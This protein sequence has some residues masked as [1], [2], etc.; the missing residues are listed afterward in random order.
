[1]RST[2]TTSSLLANLRYFY[3]VSDELPPLHFNLSLSDWYFFS[4]CIYKSFFSGGHPHRCSLQPWLQNDGASPRSCRL[5]P[6]QDASEW[7]RNLSRSC[8]GA[9][10][11]SQPGSGFHSKAFG[12]GQQGDLWLMLMLRTVLML[13][14]IIIFLLLLLLIKFFKVCALLEVNTANFQCSYIDLNAWDLFANNTPTM[15]WERWK[16]TNKFAQYSFLG[17]LTSDVR[18]IIGSLPVTHA[19]LCQIQ[20]LLK[21]IKTLLLVC[22]L[23]MKE[24]RLLFLFCP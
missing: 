23:F 4:W 12:S 8:R 20:E 19:D 2:S 15:D 21:I 7:K 3:I 13:M 17:S 14:F 22:K 5:G 1:M 9:G 11:R 6:L 18:F 24:W 16:P 10:G